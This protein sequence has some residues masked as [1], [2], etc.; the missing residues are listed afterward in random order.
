[1][2]NPAMANSYQNLIT[3]TKAMSAEL[4]LERSN[5]DLEK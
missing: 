3:I 2:G 4:D 5:I 1:M